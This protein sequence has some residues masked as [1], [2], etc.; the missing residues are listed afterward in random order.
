MKI[1]IINLDH[2]I[3][4]KKKMLEELNKHQITDFEFVSAVNGKEL[5]VDQMI[6][7]GLIKIGDR[8]LRDGEYGCYLSHINVLQ[9]ILTSDCELH[10]VLEDDIYFDKHFTTKFRRLLNQLQKLNW[11]IFYVGLNN[12]MPNGKDGEQIRPGIYCPKYSVWGTHAYLIKKP[13]VEKLA[14]CWFP[15]VLP[16]DIHLM[17]SNIRRLALTNPIVKVLDYNDSDTLEVRALANLNN[18]VH[19]SAF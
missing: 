8:R 9:S 6:Q 19:E 12:H 14:N 18:H 3:D 11:D 2:R 4:R 7:D 1:H 5:A 17:T 13:T 15:I 16:W 10:L